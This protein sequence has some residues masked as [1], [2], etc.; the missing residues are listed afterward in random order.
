M[1]LAL[2]TVTHVQLT[3]VFLG[4]HLYFSYSLNLDS[5]ID[6][7]RVDNL[8]CPDG[9]IPFIPKHSL[10]WL[11]A[12]FPCSLTLTVSY[13]VSAGLAKRVGARLL[14]ASTSEVYGGEWVSLQ[15]PGQLASVTAVGRR[16]Q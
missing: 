15:P 7:V 9:Q 5:K 12:C 6:A 2:F 4:V 3:A 16:V 8:Q 14:L 13:R 1:R 10:N 11:Y